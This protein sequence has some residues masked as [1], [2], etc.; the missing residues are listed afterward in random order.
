MN[1]S[2]FPVFNSGRPSTLS[3]RTS[4]EIEHQIKAEAKSLRLSTSELLNDLLIKFLEQRNKQHLR[5]V[6]L[7]KTERARR[8]R[9]IVKELRELWSDE[10]EPA[11]VKRTA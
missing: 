2:K 1:V 11:T 8:T 7:T 4:D 3:C 6:G 10:S 9:E 5:I